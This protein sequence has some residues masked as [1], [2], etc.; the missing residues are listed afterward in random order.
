MLAARPPLFGGHHASGPV[1]A[2]GGGGGVALGLGLSHARL[3]LVL[4]VWGVV[5][6]RMGVWRGVQALGQAVRRLGHGRVAVLGNG[7]AMVDF[8]WH[9]FVDK[10]RT[11]CVA[12]TPEVKTLF[13]HVRQLAQVG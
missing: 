11:L 7:A 4:G 10:F 9:L 3:A 6:A 5:S 1:T 13:N 2:A 12:P 8:P